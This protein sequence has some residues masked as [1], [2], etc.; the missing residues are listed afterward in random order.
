M[1]QYLKVVFL[2]T[3]FLSIVPNAFALEVVSINCDWSQNWSVE[4]PIVINFNQSYHGAELFVNI[5]KE[6]GDGFNYQLTLLDLDW[7]NEKKLI[8][9]DKLEF[10]T[11]Y[12][13]EVHVGD[14]V[15][16]TVFFKT[17]AEAQSNHAKIKI[18]DINADGK[19]GLFEAINILKK[20]AGF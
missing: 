17:A 6:W 3:I 10:D 4:E 5:W 1:K 12:K 8:I 13:L 19:I 16:K 18:D 11:S 15:V 7:D 20:T 14:D 9:N 2:A